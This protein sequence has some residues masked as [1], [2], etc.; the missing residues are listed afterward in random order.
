MCVS[1]G[2]IRYRGASL[3]KR[4][5]I[6]WNHRYKTSMIILTYMFYRTVQA[7]NKYKYENN[8]FVHFEPCLLSLFFHSCENGMYLLNFSQSPPPLEK[9]CLINFSWVVR[10]D[11]VKAPGLEIS[12]LLSY[13]LHVPEVQNQCCKV[14]ERERYLDRF[15]L[16]ITIKQNYLVYYNSY[17]FF[18]NIFFSNFVILL[19]SFF[20]I[21][22]QSEHEY[23][24]RCG[25]FG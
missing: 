16:K 21:N 4:H 7:I 12:E 18:H 25:F 10:V 8:K 22:C 15:A 24:W 2:Q 17:Y 6:N 11:D 13:P 5:E 19:N 3:L 23:L 1:E 14:R 9:K 20:T